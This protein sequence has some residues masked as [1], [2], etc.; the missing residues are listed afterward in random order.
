MYLYQDLGWCVL[1][2]LRPNMDFGKIVQKLATSP[3][4]GLY[5]NPKLAEI[6]IINVEITDTTE[7]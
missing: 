1:Y 4:S 3:S 6:R 5:S 2:I 7:D